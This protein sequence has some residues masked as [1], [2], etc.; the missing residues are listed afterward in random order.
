MLSLLVLLVAA[1]LRIT[2]L[3]ALPPGPHFDEAANLLIARSIAFG[4]ADLF[5]IANS[6]QG[7]ETLYHYASAGLFHLTGESPFT[8]RVVS[9]YAGMLAVA[10]TLALGRAMF[11]GWRGVVVG[12]VAGLLLAVSLHHVALS[13]QM[14]RA[15]TLPTMQALALLFLFRGLRTRRGGWRWLLAG[16]VFAG[17]ALYTYMASRLF[18]VWLLIAALALL[19]WDRGRWRLRVGQGLLFFGALTITALPMGVYA[20]QNPD[21]FLGRL[22]E[23]T[24]AAEDEG[25]VTLATSIRRHAEMF[26]L[27]GE[28]GN[29]RY[30]PPG[31][32]YFTPVE[33]VLFLVG[34]AAAASRV[35]RP[36]DARA[37]SAALLALLAP[38]MVLPGVVAVAGLPPNHM[39][40]LGMVPLLFV[41]VALGAEALIKASR[42][43]WPGVMRWSVGLFVLAL[44]AGSALTWRDYHA[45]ITRADLFYQSDGDLAAAARWLPGA[46]APGAPVY[47]A[48]FHREHPTV[49]ALWDGPVTWLGFDSLVLPPPG[50]SG[51]L[52]LAHAAPIPA[53]WRD[54]LAAYALAG[55]PAGPDGGPAFEAYRLPGDAILGAA[56]SPAQPL[57]GV[58]NPYLTLLGISAEPVP[59]GERGLLTLVWRVEATPPYARLRPVVTLRAPN[60]AAL[61]QT[62]LFLL[63]ADDW[64][65]GETVVQQIPVAVPPGT[66]PGDY[67]LEAAW[68]DR[69]SDTYIAYT[70]AAGAA[71]VVAQIGALPVARPAEPPTLTALAIPE[72]PSADG[73]VAFTQGVALLGWSLPLETARPGET[74]LGT[75][76]W[77][78]APT[79]D[80]A[81]RAALDYRPLLRAADGASTPLVPQATPL[82]DRYP[83]AGW[84]TGERLADHVAW[85]IPPE[86]AAREYTLVLAGPA[87]EVTLGTLRVEG[88]PRRFEPPPVSVVTDLRYGDSLALHGYTLMLD[89][90]ANQLTLDL[91]WQA[92]APVP[93]DYTVFVHL[94]A[95]DGRIIEQRDAMP[96]SNSYPTS[97]WAAGEYIPDSY[98]LNL[99][100][101]LPEAGGAGDGYSVRVGL[102]IQATGERLAV[103]WEER[104]LPDDYF[105]ITL[106][107]SGTLSNND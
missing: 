17:G 84:L 4:G 30:N 28:D 1:L 33:G 73:L 68:V 21:I 23:V 32:P 95:P 53:A 22:D 70:G 107:D 31:R 75:L 15:I 56:L 88:L 82:A 7:R 105:V 77:E 100:T 98:T 48:A 11:G 60:G 29:L 16:G 52:I 58:G 101:G 18:P 51:T 19:W 36:G 14:F 8:M 79:P 12:L 93:V 6:Y 90:D 25:V 2:A 91:V 83:P 106:L 61:A 97:L 104:K 78:A 39:R 74:L 49:L 27:R 37:R 71:G 46:T 80:A 34:I 76:Y 59:A 87:V 57:T 5:P 41:L 24:T 96:V 64:R 44:L 38:L 35:L 89:T 45:W 42:A 102:Y 66:P 81:P 40:S 69:D 103:L 9:V 72:S 92:L 10:A 65:P 86:V 50:Q 20:L 47:V 13:R 85:R 67:T 62:D 55:A 94:V 54:W 63:G 43:R 3:S 26:F 99:P